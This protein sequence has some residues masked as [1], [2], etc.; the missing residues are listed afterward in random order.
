MKK[1]L[2]SKITA[3]A[4]VVSPLFILGAAVF[5][6]SILLLEI[7]AINLLFAC[8]C[9]ACAVIWSIYIKS[10]ANQIY[11]W[12]VFGK[13]SVTIKTFF[14]KQEII[15]YSDCAACGIAVYTHGVLNSSVGTKQYFIFLSRD[16]FD[17]RFRTRINLWRPSKTR[18]KVQFSKKLYDYLLTV[19]PEFQAA[20]IKRDYQKFMKT[21]TGDGS[22]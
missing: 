5:G 10:V 21:N 19:L 13:E 6:A 14:Q 17:E 11:S 8:M 4:A 3:F 2:G 1:Y 22:Q 12:G 20:S 16:A 15:N 7:N 9:L 18:I